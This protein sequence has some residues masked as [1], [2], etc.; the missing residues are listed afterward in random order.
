MSE[1]FNTY[2]KNILTIERK[3]ENANYL[4]TYKTIGRINFAKIFK[5]SVNQAKYIIENKDKILNFRIENKDNSKYYIKD[6][7][8]FNNIEYLHELMIQ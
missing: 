2:L 6:I 8:K 5:I 3:K 7:N 4:N 1:D